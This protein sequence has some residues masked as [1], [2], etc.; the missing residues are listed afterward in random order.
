MTDKQ[1]L[2]KLCTRLIESPL[3]DSVLITAEHQ[4]DKRAN[5]GGQDGTVNGDDWDEAKNIIDTARAFAFAAKGYRAR[6]D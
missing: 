1:L 2:H 4:H 3:D 6:N 5:R